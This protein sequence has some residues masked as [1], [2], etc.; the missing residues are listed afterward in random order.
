MTTLEKL[1][2]IFNDAGVPSGRI[3]PEA[4]LEKDLGID[5]LD[6]ME[7]VIQIEEEWSIDISD[8]DSDNRM[9]TVADTIKLIDELVK[10]EG[11]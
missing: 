7:L 10:E 11:E 1:T 5:S 2:E 3:C 4:E 8:G 6:R 9:N